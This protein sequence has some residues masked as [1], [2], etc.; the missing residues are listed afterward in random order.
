MGKKFGFTLS[1]F[2]Y[3]VIF[4]FVLISTMLIIVG[5]QL[6]SNISRTMDYN[7]VI[8]TAGGYIS[9]KEREYGSRLEVQG[10]MLVFYPILDNEEYICRIYHD[11]GRLMESLK[12][13]ESEFIWGEG[14]LIAPLDK[15]EIHQQEG[16]VLITMAFGGN[17][18]LKIL[19]GGGNEAG[20]IV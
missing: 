19:Q 8:R 6:Y 17:E 15:F 13:L 5:S 10:D 3:V 14:E 4:V 1:L 20:Q 16:K 7:F 18:V 12:P 9:N 2:R 11:Q